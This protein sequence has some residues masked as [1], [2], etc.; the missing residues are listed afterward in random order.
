MKIRSFLNY[1]KAPKEVNYGKDLTQPNLSYSIRQL[2]E[3]STTGFF[4]NIEREAIHLGETDDPM[5]MTGTDLDLSDLDKIR[6]YGDHL[7]ES[8][9]QKFEQKEELNKQIKN[10]E[11]ILET[12]AV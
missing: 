2:L 5:L 7:S 12:P 10:E 9:K 6:Q 4:P 8:I 3:R 11:P 1:N